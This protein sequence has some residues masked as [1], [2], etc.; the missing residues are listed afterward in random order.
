LKTKFLNI[1]ISIWAIIT[2]GLFFITLKE[3]KSI[4]KEKQFHVVRSD[5]WFYHEYVVIYVFGKEPYSPREEHPINRYTMGMAITYMPAISVGYVITEI[6]GIDHNAGKNYIYQHVLFYLGLLYTLAGLIFLRLILKKWFDEIAI[7]IVL[8]LI[9]FGT[10]LYYYNIN[11][12]IMAHPVSFL[13]VTA[14]VYFSLQWIKKPTFKTVLLAGFT[15]GFATL[16]RPTNLIIIFIPLVYVL[17]KN[18]EGVSIKNFSRSHWVQIIL[19][20]L[21]SFLVFFPQMFYWH[22]YTGI[23]FNYSYGKEGFFF[24]KPAILQVLFSFRKGWFIYTP[25]MLFTIPG[26]VICYRNNKP[27]FWAIITFFILNLYIISSWWCW[28][29]G[30]SFGMRSLIDC[31]GIL[32]I[33]MAY[34]ISYIIKSKIW[35]KIPIG[36]LLGFLVYLNLY[37]TRQ[38]RICRIHYDSMTFAAYKQVFL[39]DELHLTKEEWE[40]MLDSPDYDSAIEGKRFW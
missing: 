32:A 17:T 2:M 8:L 35:V 40:A 19:A 23:W 18:P 25:I 39:T 33:F 13:L 28:W 7:T 31:Y 15:I 36:L 4:G 3:I 12:P 22:Y 26:A 9:F 6:K 1:P 11:E 20:G 10:N 37:Q 24:D 34:T 5:A 21:V 38:A 29:Y 16:I 27:V 14:F 30:G